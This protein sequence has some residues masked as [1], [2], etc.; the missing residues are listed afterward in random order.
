MKKIM[1]IFLFVVSF[2]TY[3][4]AYTI[5]RSLNY[6]QSPASWDIA[7]TA[8]NGVDVQAWA[9]TNRY[10]AS[11]VVTGTY[12][13]GTYVTV[14]S[15]YQVVGVSWPSTASVPFIR[16]SISLTNPNS[17]N[18]GPTGNNPTSGQILIK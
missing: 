4:S 7:V 17:C 15:Y 8:P 5:I 10:C 18:G 11:A 14:G 12:S 13:N 9:G 1:L 6:G 3:S 16:F 2:Q